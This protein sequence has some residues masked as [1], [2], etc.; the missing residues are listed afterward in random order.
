MSEDLRAADHRSDGPDPDLARDVARALRTIRD[1]PEPGV[2]FKD[3]T[4]LLLDVPLRDRVVADVVARRGTGV[5]LVIGIEAR[6]FI[7]GSVIAHGLGTGFVPVRK[8]GKLPSTTHAVSYSLEYGEATIE[9]HQ[10]AIP[11]GARVLI[12]DDVLA[13]GGTAAAAV[14][15][16][17][18]T[19]GEVVA[20]EVILE[21][22]FLQ[23][24]S[25]L[26]GTTVHALL[27]D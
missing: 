17:R 1:F 26:T 12:V 24:R 21:I 22:G 14:E 4:P 11:A 3:F 23:G 25:R 8:A 15:L 27:T 7:L 18:R 6:G 13:T 19:Q 10:D 16:V 5:D 20:L 2:V 9:V